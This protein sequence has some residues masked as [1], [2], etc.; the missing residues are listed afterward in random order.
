MV[1]DEVLRRIREAIEQNKIDLE[2]SEQHLSELPIAVT[3]LEQVK[4]LYLDNNSLTELPAE[5]G[6]MTQLTRLYLNHN[7]LT[8]LPPEI[9]QLT[10]LTHLYL[11]DNYLTSLPAE[12]GQ[13]ENLTHLYLRNNQLTALPEE[14]TQLQNL[15]RLYLSDNKLTVLPVGLE[16]L[17]QLTQLDVR[18]NPIAPATQNSGDTASEIENPT[19]VIK[20]YLAQ[21]INPANETKVMVLGRQ[22]SGKTSVL[23]RLIAGDFDR[24]EEPTEGMTNYAWTVQ[25]TAER[26]IQLNVWDVG[27]DRELYAAHQFFI[28]REGLYLVVV[29]NSLSE[30]ESHLEEWLLLVRAYSGGSPV[31]V[32]GN[33]AD[34]APLRGNRRKLCDRYPFIRG[35]AEVSCSA[36]RGFE[37]LRE[38]IIRELGTLSRFNDNLYMS[39]IAV[40]QH[41]E[42][43][44]ENYLEYSEYQA[45]CSSKEI[46]QDQEQRQLLSLLHDLGIVMFYFEDPRLDS[47][48]IINPY[49][50]SYGMYAILNDPKIREE[51]KGV[52]PLSYL[53]ELFGENT[54][55][56]QLFV[57]DMMRRFELGYFVDGRRFLLPTLMPDYRPPVQKWQSS[58]IY[59][60]RYEVLPSVIFP[61]LVTRIRQFIFKRVI[62]ANGLVLADQEAKNKAIVALDQVTSGLW[63]WVGGDVQTAENL[64]S[65]I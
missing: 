4:V 39:W 18:K 56:D 10:N 23:R 42:N 13:L 17:P 38:M 41:L 51:Y 33:K 12:I 29:D 50:L 37:T 9:G 22:G 63:I 62:W 47:T 6:A 65:L 61:R 60:Y 35:F 26:N 19:E 1:S 11:R 46:S 53:D 32:V 43:F 24:N 57:I 44:T 3:N 2:L 31:I 54:Q 64:V 15:K 40:K 59:C 16:G 30:M 49:S 20:R 45:L 14:I 8:T 27:G 58:L 25:L 7:R 28:T 21:Q 48:D 55:N 36:N 52:L 34:L 5:I